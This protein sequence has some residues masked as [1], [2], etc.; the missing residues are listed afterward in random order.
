[1]SASVVQSSIP[2]RAGSPLARLLAEL[3]Q[4]ITH[5]TGRFASLA[6]PRPVNAQE[7]AAPQPL[8]PVQE[9]LRQAAAS[10]AIPKGLAGMLNVVVDRT[11]S[12]AR[13]SAAG[14]GA[15]TILAGLE[16]QAHSAQ[17][18]HTKVRAVGQAVDRTEAT[19][20]DAQRRIEGALAEIYKNPKAAMTA[21]R[22]LQNECGGPGRTAE[23]VRETPTILC[24]DGGIFDDGIK[25]G[26][27]A[28]TERMAALTAVPLLAAAIEERGRAVQ[29]MGIEMDTLRS[30]KAEPNNSRAL[31]DALRAHATLEAVQ[32]CVAGPDPLSSIMLREGAN[33]TA[34]AATLADIHSA[35]DIPASYRAM[36]ADQAARRDNLDALLNVR[37]QPG[38]AVATFQT[39]M[40]Q[41]VQNGQAATR[42]S[43]EGLIYPAQQAEEWS[44]MAMGKAYEAAS[45]IT[46]DYVENAQA[47]QANMLHTVESFLRTHGDEAR[48][49][50]DNYSDAP[51]MPEA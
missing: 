39:A 5:G 27:F 36:M 22:K 12:L 1:M 29:R 8:T 18:Y 19:V 3:G 44:R 47:V 50:H 30:L 34:A 25:G 37:P 28:A 9:A 31:A 48:Q 17:Q 14:F 43:R 15:S 21:L 35:P 45:A 41:V 11:A 20:Q 4:H 7:S 32:A 2:C 42:L 33:Q 23:I 51:S 26:F 49:H 13:R 46:S 16:D 38:G 10:G 24:P 40:A 6:R